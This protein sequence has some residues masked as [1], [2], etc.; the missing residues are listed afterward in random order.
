M[1]G[2]E[3]CMGAE[4]SLLWI[5]DNKENAGF[6]EEEVSQKHIS[7]SESFEMRRRK[8][9]EEI[10]VGVDFIRSL[11]LKSDN[12]G[13][14]RMD[15]N[16]PDSDSLL[17]QIHSFAFK[18]GLYLRGYYDRKCSDFTSE[19]YLLESKYLSNDE[20]RFADA[21]DRNGNPRKID[22]IFAYKVPKFTQVLWSRELPIV[23]E[24]IRNCCL[25]H[26][27]SGVDFFWI[28]DIGK[29]N[30][31][32]FFGLIAEEMVA[33]FA[34]DRYLSYSGM[35]YAKDSKRDHSVYSPLYQRFLA[36][37]GKL[38]E[39]SQMFY[40]LRITVPIQLPRNKMPQTDFA[41]VYYDNRW[42]YGRQYALIRK[43][44]ADILL[45][46]KAIQKEYLTPVLLYDTEPDGYY[47]QTSE[48]ISYP[49]DTV[50]AKLENEYEKL[51]RNPRPQRSASE[52]D[53]LKLL[54]M[55]KK[56]NPENFHKGLSRKKMEALA[57]TPFEML[58]SYYSITD[59]G[60]LSAEYHF[61]PY[62]ESLEETPIY[63]E[64]INKEELHTNRHSGIVIAKCADGDTVI[65][66]NDGTVKRI[67]HE[68]MDS[69]E[70]WDT[71][72]QFF[73]DAI[74]DTQDDA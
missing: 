35:K 12:V 25:N 72:A 9:E 60:F 2:R 46:E 39:L 27:F 21:V 68:T 66:C 3:V 64:Q 71:V 54:R 40:D 65:A 70:S 22:E 42:D 29:Y 56:R 6:C 41:Y 61:M 18:E 30:A 4:E 58:T 38:P 74:S 15:L 48:P 49:S 51:K 14:C 52:K 37:G 20:K 17:E 69:Y 19:W 53:A 73:F 59:G 45:S 63:T 57:A 36:L 26:G 47:I 5:L 67:S 13:W 10:K 23:T 24:D 16:R 1:T 55:K 11:G 8:Q 50:I 34:C 31:A 43:R 32:Q 33:E 62:S 44:A 7:R 28:R